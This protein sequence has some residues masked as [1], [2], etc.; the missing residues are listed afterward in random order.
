MELE[1]DIYSQDEN[2]L[3]RGY[4]T[5]LNVVGDI[6]VNEFLERYQG[7]FIEDV[8][9]QHLDY[10]KESFGIIDNINYIKSNLIYF[11]KN[12]NNLGDL[13]L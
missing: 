7:L 11:L 3:L 1:T 4:F 10:L 8:V 2:L 5:Y 6:P 9:R 12:Y 13:K